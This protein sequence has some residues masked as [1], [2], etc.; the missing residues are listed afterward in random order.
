[1][2]RPPAWRRY[3]RFFGPDVDADVDEELHFHLEQRVRHYERLGM[4]RQQAEHAATE[5]FGDVASVRSALRVHDRSRQRRREWREHMRHLL[6]EFRYALR[7]LRLQRG[8]AITAVLT[9]ALGVGANATVFGI[10]DQLLFRPP[11]YVRSPERIEM[12][13]VRTHGESGVGQQTFNYP[14]YRTLRQQLRTIDAIAIASWGAIDLPVGRGAQA[15]SARG[16]LVSSSYFG[17]LGVTPE[18]GRFFASEEDLPPSGVPVVVI[19]DGFWMRQFGRD[20]DALGRRIDI[21]DQRYTIIGIAPRGFTGTE[22]GRV[23]LWVPL[24]AGMHLLMPIDWTTV[25][26]ASYAHIFVRIRPRVQRARSA[27]EIER[28]LQTS[29][30]DTWFMRDRHVWLTP[31]VA[32]RSVNVGTNGLITVLLAVMAVIVLLIACA[33]LANLLLVRALRRQ[34]EIAVRVALGISRARLVRLLITES[35]VVAMLGAMG[36]LLLIQWSGGVV[37]SVLFADVPLVGNPVDGRVATFAAVAALIAGVAAA[38][39]PAVQTSQPDL[40]RALKA[41]V[42]T[43][44]GQRA[45]TRTGLL[46]VQSALAVVLL[47]GAGLFVR[48]MQLVTDQHMGVDTDRVLTGFLPLSSVGYSKPE[49]RAVYSAALERVR[50]L[51]GI[52]H[53]AVSLTIPFGPSFGLHVRL[54]NGDTLPSGD[55][56]FVNAISPD[57]FSTIGAQLVAGRDFTPADVG[58]APRVTIVSAAMARRLWHGRSAVG[59]CL[60][61]DSDSLPCARV[62]G[63]AEDVRRQDILENPLYA[64][65]VPLA[66]AGPQVSK[67]LRDLYLVARPVGD[68]SRM[69]EPV[70]RAMYAAAPALPFA[71]VQRISDMPELVTQLRR[72]QLAATL[73]AAFGALALALAA[74]G[75]FGVISYTVAQRAHEIGVRMALGAAPSAVARVVIA[76]AM[77]LTAGGVAL[78]VAGSVAG[79][80]FASAALYGVSPHDPFV[81]AIVVV[82]LLLA[83]MIASAIPAY[84]ATRVDPIRVLRAD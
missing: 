82:I 16:L 70:R 29:F 62:I 78:G 43:G 12:L 71:Q 54:S 41:T 74:V 69:I 72:W 7:G 64:L 26:Q 27:A 49:V 39:V 33:N 59:Q 19:S 35:V 32:A 48:S 45:R 37:R 84:R 83:S 15:L 13:S 20:P 53:A 67:W 5:R 63:V 58:G 50:V 44:G 56:P 47:V 80:A 60:L 51:P 46:I 66:Q 30:G 52:E 65:Y 42:R 38:L 1:M 76:D 57:Y 9:I 24:A 77:K 8:F 11:A 10:I 75:L 36:A 25:V 61:I 14:I 68:A 23:D 73:F 4:S 3:L 34:H 22:L 6:E 79:G 55:G 2:T 21:G 17:L 81:I 28:V 31:L 40:T 18:R